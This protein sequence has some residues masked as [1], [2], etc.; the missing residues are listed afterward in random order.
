MVDHDGSA[1]AM[2]SDNLTVVGEATPQQ[3]GIEAVPAPEVVVAESIARGDVD[4]ISGSL[5]A[6]QASGALDE[7]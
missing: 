7:E 1:R 3:M 6:G 4:S 2:K 5:Q